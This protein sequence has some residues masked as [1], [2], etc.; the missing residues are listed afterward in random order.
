MQVLRVCR[1]S[2]FA[3]PPALPPCCCP[4]AFQRQVRRLTYRMSSE[5]YPGYPECVVSCHGAGRFANS[6]G[7]GTVWAGDGQDS[8]VGWE[9][10]CKT[11]LMP[12]RIGQVK[13]A[14]APAGILWWGGR[15][16]TLR[17]HPLIQGVHILHPENGPAPPGRRIGR[18]DHEID[19]RL[20]ALEGTE[21]DLG[22]AK[23]QRK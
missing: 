12:V 5:S 14:L 11:Q 19:K 1:F 8:P 2:T 13:A 9:E 22:S 7:R 21:R 23:D 17:A 15:R 18:C 16:E 3:L 10:L 20:P 6:I 4:L